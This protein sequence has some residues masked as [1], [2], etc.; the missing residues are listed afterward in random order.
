MKELRD[1]PR[2]LVRAP[3]WIG[4]VILSLPAVRDLR[5]NFP[6]ARL[7]VLARGWVAD[8]YRAVPQVDAIR[9]SRGHRA[10]VETIRGAFDAALL[11]PNSFGAALAVWR[12]GIKERWGYATD[13]RGPLLTRRA[14]VP[15]SVRGR[16][17]VYYY[18]AMLAEPRSRVPRSGALGARPS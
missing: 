8:L 3:N 2:L 7:E 17:Q 13:G 6:D 12:A 4:D 18:R 5:R 1:V 11:L 9:E 16:S 14:R 10:D 15:A